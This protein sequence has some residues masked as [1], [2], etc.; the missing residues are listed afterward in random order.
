MRQ[1][2]VNWI[3]R[4]SYSFGMR[5]ELQLCAAVDAHKELTTVLLESAQHIVFVRCFTRSE[6]DS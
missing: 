6:H 4:L 2:A 3:L 1:H 5:R